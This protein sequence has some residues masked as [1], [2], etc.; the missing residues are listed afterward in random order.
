MGRSPAVWLVGRPVRAGVA[1]GVAGLVVVGGF[2]VVR[3]GHRLR[4]RAGSGQG[5]GPFGVA[6]R[7]PG[8]VWHPLGLVGRR[9]TRPP[10][11]TPPT[12]EC[13]VGRGGCRPG[14][15]GAT[16]GRRCLSGAAGRIC[17]LISSQCGEPAALRARPQRSLVGHRRSWSPWSGVHVAG[18]ARRSPAASWWPLFSP[19]VLLGRAAPTV[20]RSCR[21]G[22]RAVADGAGRRWVG[23]QPADEEPGSDDDDTEDPAA[24]EEPAVVAA[25]D[26]R[27]A[28]AAALVQERFDRTSCALADWITAHPGSGVAGLVPDRAAQR[29]DV[30]WHGPVPAGVDAVAARVRDGVPVRFRRAAHSQAE[31]VRARDAVMTARLANSPLT[32]PLAGRGLT[33]QTGPVQPDG[34]GVDFMVAPTSTTVPAPSAADLAWAR[35]LFAALVGVPFTVT[36]GSAVV[37]V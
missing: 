7:R 11:A 15:S 3:A 23:D 28:R 25:V 5:R 10:A 2:S 17:A 29:L 26:G 18:L 19:R 9:I 27:R 1:C 30:W 4:G 34:S 20:K 33:L 21:V 22:E 24:E 31:L 16:G 36:A 35:T 32:K 8:A 6:L 37:P 14:G 13:A 12:H